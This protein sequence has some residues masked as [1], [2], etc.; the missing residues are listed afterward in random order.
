MHAFAR[1]GATTPVLGYG[2]DSNAK[3]Y[4]LDGLEM[5]LVGTLDVGPVRNA[6]GLCAMHKE[7]N[8]R[9]VGAAVTP[10][11]AA[12]HAVVEY[13]MLCDIRPSSEAGK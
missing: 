4:L 3:K 6:L 8:R 2:V 5:N 12:W 1:E 7:L 11:H 9:D 13:V 10:R